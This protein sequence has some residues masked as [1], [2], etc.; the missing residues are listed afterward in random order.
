MKVIYRGH[1]TLLLPR[2]CIGIK[3]QLLVLSSDLD[4]NER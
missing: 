2:A 4:L 1:Q 3:L